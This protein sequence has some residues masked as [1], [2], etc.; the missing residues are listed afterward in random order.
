MERRTRKKVSL[1]KARGKDRFKIEIDG[2]SFDLRTSSSTNVGRRT[3][4][5]TKP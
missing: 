3:I 1:R 2:I 5:L 4:E